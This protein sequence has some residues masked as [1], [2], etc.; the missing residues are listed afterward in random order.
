[1]K[2][3][4]KDITNASIKV[5]RCG[6][7]YKG[8]RLELG[9]PLTTWEKVLGKPSR[10]TDLTQVWDSLGIG[11]DD[12]Q[13]EKKGNVAAVYIYFV[14]LDSPE[15]KEGLL[16]YAKDWQPF[17]R[18]DWDEEFLKENETRLKE[19]ADP[20]NYVYPLTVYNGYVD[21]HGFP[22]GAGM[23]V[24]EINRYRENL[25]FSSKF[26]YVDQDIDGVND[27]GNTTDTF[28]G[29][30]RATGTECKEGGL[31]YYELTYTASGALE[32]LTIGYEPKQELEDKIEKQ[33]E[34][35]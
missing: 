27:S 7:F 11:V 24:D 23:K 15:G 28:G 13:G 21:L 2:N 16:N 9:M 6:I 1:M 22:V 34:N 10:K 35:E 8:E 25:P 33:R 5:E 20:K 32:F 3:K 26:G 14:K 17:N 19:K 12:W 29:D 18:D 31:Q 4:D 30:Y